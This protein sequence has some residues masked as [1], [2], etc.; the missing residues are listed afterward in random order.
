MRVLVVNAGSSSLRIDVLDPT[1]RPVAS[2]TH[3][4]LSGS[5]LSGALSEALD[6]GGR[7]DASGH[8]LVHGGERFTESTLL[9]AS[10]DDELHALDDLAPL[11]NPPALAAIEALRRLRPELPAVACFDTAFHASLPA[12][13]ST[14]AL[15]TQW[16]TRWP[17]RRYGFHGLSHSWIAKR[18]PE[19]LDRPPGR[20]RIISCHLGAGASLAAID[21]SRS[22]DTTMGFTP[23]DGL[24]MATRSGAVD[25]GLLLWVQR[26]GK[27][28]PEEAERALTEDAGLLGLSG[29]SG[30]FRE[31]LA[32]A[33]A[34]DER[35][36]LALDVYVHRLRA[37]VAA[38]AA[39]M[40][41][42]DAVAFT[43]GVGEGSPWVR[44]EAAAGLGFLGLEVDP[45]LNGSP[46]FADRFVS[47]PG[48]RVPALVV[49]AREDLRI[50]AEVRRCLTRAGRAET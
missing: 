2:W 27:I 30:D 17:L 50:A 31:I 18:V 7:V 4:P 24:V 35:C 41:G 11:H 28:G 34:G 26:H 39:A 38:M 10:L 37:G 44:T 1:G 49:R 46:D 48:A 32:A 47:R 45:S 36:R 9:D 20:T 29:R 5:D 19:L 23:L 12:A 43:G 16:A 14:Y 42:V 33:G 6:A 21:R 13:A 22:V 3:P 15:P 25:P 8:R 40:G